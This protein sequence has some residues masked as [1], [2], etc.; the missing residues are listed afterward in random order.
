MKNIPMLQTY[1]LQFHAFSPKQFL[2]KWIHF[3]Q[4]C[5]AF[6]PNTF[7]NIYCAI[8]RRKHLEFPVQIESRFIEKDASLINQ[9]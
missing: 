8:F 7:S 5:F 6:H 1:P 4:I 3:Q 2:Q 9:Y